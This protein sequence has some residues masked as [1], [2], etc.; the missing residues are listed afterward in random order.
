MKMMADGDMPLVTSYGG[1]DIEFNT[2]GTKTSKSNSRLVFLSKFA[3]FEKVYKGKW[4][5][6]IS[7]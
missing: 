6:L 2:N 5:L 7:R 1:S 4:S 3:V